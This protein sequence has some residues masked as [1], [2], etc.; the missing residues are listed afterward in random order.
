LTEWVAR[1]EYG[2]H[3]A[4]GGHDISGVRVA[5]EVDHHTPNQEPD[6]IDE[7]IT[8]CSKIL[9]YHLNN[10][11]ADIGYTWLVHGD[12]AIEGRG[13][14]RTGAHAPGANSNSVG[15]AFL[16]D[17]RNRQPT[18]TEW[19]TAKAIMDRGVAEGF[20]SPAYLVRG[21]RDFVLTECPAIHVYSHIHDP[22]GGTPILVPPP[23]H[24]PTEEYGMAKQ[25]IDNHG[26]VWAV[27]GIFKTPINDDGVRQH[28]VLL[29]LLE[30]TVTKVEDWQLAEL[31]L[32]S[33]NPTDE[34]AKSGETV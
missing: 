12:Y 32:V 28:M 9:G 3:L 14:G 22:R 4:R 29:G 31:V 34:A 27:D 16:L 10:G 18:A 15:I 30:P 26:T 17:G 25:F 11:W 13:F 19:S 6:S 1:S 21:H 7:A 20:V 5:Y 8:E 23:D 2:N 33:D 24:A